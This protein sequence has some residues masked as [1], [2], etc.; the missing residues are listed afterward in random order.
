MEL[1]DRMD[2]LASEMAYDM[3]GWA[4]EVEARGVKVIHLEIGEPDFDTPGHIVDAA[5]RALQLGRTHYEV[6]S[7]LNELR[8][9]A[10]REVCRTRGVDCEPGQVVVMPGGKPA[11][12]LSI[13]ALVNPGDEVIYPNP[14]YPAYESVVNFVGGIPVP[15]ALKEETGFAF[16]LDEMQAKLSPRTKMIIINSPH[17]PT[18]GVLGDRDLSF[19]AKIAVEQ[20][21]VV[22][23]DE[24]YRRML[25]EDEYYSILSY[26]GMSERTI[27]ADS[28]SKI[29]AMTG[30]R[31]GFAVVPKW[32]APAMNLLVINSVSCTTTF[33]QYAGI[34]AL[35]GDQ[36]A[37]EA[38]VAEFRRRRDFIVEGLN[39]IPGVSCL[40]PKGA[41]YVF[42]NVA[43]L[44]VKSMDLANYWLQ[45][46]GVATLPGT[47]FGEQGEG[48]MRLS[49]A[50]SIENIGIALERM[51]EG[52]EKLRS[53]RATIPNG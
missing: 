4:R 37:P 47:A 31:L 35:E 50:N 23:S 10:A 13:L 48:Y 12:F 30:W 11:V 32:L 42:P 41:F 14:G 46:C 24:I 52:V 33:N 29:Y 15:V 53:G 39:A 9:A 21:L 49:Y 5:V 2:K 22:L 40:L 7:G 51:A 27:V 16:D 34:A 19:I 28:F 3:L 44:G 8:R 26:P 17:N 1:A 45:E 20:G 38:M 25:Y 18:G 36:S 43:A 6:P